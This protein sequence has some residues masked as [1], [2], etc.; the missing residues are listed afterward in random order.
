MHGPQSSYSTNPQPLH[1][2]LDLP[3]NFVLS[4]SSTDPGNSSCVTLS[5]ISTMQA[6]YIEEN[7]PQA[8]SLSPPPNLPP[9][10]SLYTDQGPQH[11]FADSS[12]PLFFMYS[13]MASEEDKKMADIWHRDADGILIVVSFI[14]HTFYTFSIQ[15]YFI[16]WSFLCRNCAIGCGDCP[17]PPAKLPG[18]VR[19][20]PQE[21]IR[22]SSFRRLKHIPSIYP[23]H[24]GSTRP[25]LPI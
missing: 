12:G 22:V 15:N 7:Q 23:C 25:L 17:E 21:Y 14:F 6:A 5:L 1:L 19:I 11:E 10:P 8:T 4:V 24:S 2:P 18:Y 9:D 16:E 3:V 20:L 13:R